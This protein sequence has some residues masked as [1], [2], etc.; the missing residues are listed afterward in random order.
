MSGFAPASRLF[1]VGVSGTALT[2]EERG[3]LERFPPWG[4]ILFRRNI[5]TPDGVRALAREISRLPGPPLLCID[6]E[7][8]PV[9]RFRDLLGRS[10]SFH[11][12]AHA[13][14][15]REAGEVAGEA[16]RA[17]G[18]DVDLAPV[19]DRDLPGASERFLA[20]R[21][22][23]AEPEEI[24]TAATAFLEG[25]HGVGIAGC[26][27]HFPG[28]GRGDLDT[29]QALPFLRDDPEEEAKDL[30]PFAA[31]MDLA[32]AVMISHAAGPEGLPAT[33]SPARAT[34]LLRGGMGF[35][36]VAFS[37]DL[38][39][40][41][42]ASFGELPDRCAEASR[43]GS[44]LLFVCSRILEYP[45]CVARVDLEV[46]GDRRREAAERLA[47]YSRRAAE[48]RAA[49]KRPTLTLEALGEATRRLHDRAS[50]NAT[51]SQT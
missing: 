30:A 27:K 49:V 17:L 26:V 21:C 51:R 25:L 19:V 47:A 18:F 4:L 13:G 23:S 9:D 31:T 36:G 5:E 44:D 3:I 34:A 39:M 20:G 1:G 40:G 15:A 37:D 12:A 6:Q 38:E 14:L 50:R 35:S 41:A 33:L 8:G 48:R 28:L 29:H 46:P 7:G 16:C 32:G 43:A 2:E 42:L 11:D 24:V 10:V 45:D 22:A